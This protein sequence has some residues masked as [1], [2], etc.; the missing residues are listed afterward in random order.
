MTT[1]SS[2][3][4]QDRISAVE[5]LRGPDHIASLSTPSRSAG[6]LAE[7]VDELVGLAA[8]RR[9]EHELGVIVAFV[10]ERRRFTVELEARRLEV[11]P[12]DCRVDA[13]QLVDEC[14]GVSAGIGD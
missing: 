7:P 12:D 8:Y 3:F 13:V 4:P 9:V 5:T 6:N 11:P 10:P 2:R 1:V 14:G